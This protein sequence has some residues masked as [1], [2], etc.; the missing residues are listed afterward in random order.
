M[1]TYLSAE[2]VVH[3]PV[4]SGQKEQLAKLLAAAMA[5]VNKHQQ[6]YEKIL[7]E[8]STDIAKLTDRSGKSTVP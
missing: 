6:A 2:K 1:D 3:L 5:Q 7:S 4:P 8:P